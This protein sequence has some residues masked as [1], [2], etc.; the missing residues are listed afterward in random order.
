[1]YSMLKNMKVIINRININLNNKNKGI[2]K[3]KTKIFSSGMQT[4]KE[5]LFQIKSIIP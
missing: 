4:K 1:M 3:N 2:F 5:T